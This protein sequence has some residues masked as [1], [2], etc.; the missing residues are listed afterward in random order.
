MKILFIS[1]LTT[2]AA[3]DPRCGDC[4][5]VPSDFATDNTCPAFVGVYQEFPDSY[6]TLYESFQLTAGA[7]TL[8]TDCFPFADSVGPIANYAESNNPR[9]TLNNYNESTVCAYLYDETESTCQGRSYQLVTYDTKADAEAAGA[10]MVHSSGCGVCS[11]AQ[12]LATRMRTLYTLQSDATAC[13]GGYVFS[14]DFEALVS[15]YQ[16][17]GFT[18]DCARLWSH[19]AATSIA[20]CAGVCAG[21]PPLNGD[22]PECALGDCLTCQQDFEGDFNDLAGIW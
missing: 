1:L 6:P 15:C 2:V 19:F 5:C 10:A 9:C 20:L 7:M 3:F 12:D 8:P 14:R 16:K 18:E 21:N 22:P 4:W 11:T 13:G 17:I